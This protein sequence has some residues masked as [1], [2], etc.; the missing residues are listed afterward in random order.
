MK[1]GRRS[2]I[3]FDVSRFDDPDTTL[4]TV[5]DADTSASTTYNLL[6][7]SRRPELDLSRS[8][9]DISTNNSFNKLPDDNMNSEL[10]RSTGSELDNSKIHPTLQP[11]G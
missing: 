6:D 2:E 11:N 8:S 10:T 1:K 7:T 4:E 5:L 3:A 9:R